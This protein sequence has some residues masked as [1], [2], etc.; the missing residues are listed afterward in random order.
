MYL[1]LMNILVGIF[2]FIITVIAVI[3]LISAVFL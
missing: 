1:E 3:Y 2:F